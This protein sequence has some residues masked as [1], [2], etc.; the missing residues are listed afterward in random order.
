MNE[1]Q[2]QLL[3]QSQSLHAIS[4]LATLDR[5]YALVLK[6]K[7]IITDART[8]TPGDKI[9]VRLAHGDVDCEVIN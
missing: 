9:N 5:G 7:H 8:L 3:R 4:P 6:D 1:K 2:K